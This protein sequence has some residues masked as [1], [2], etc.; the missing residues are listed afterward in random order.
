MVRAATHVCRGVRRAEVANLDNERLDSRRGAVARG[1][2]GAWVALQHRCVASSD[3]KEARVAHAEASC[4]GGLGYRRGGRTILEPAT[5]ERERGCFIAVAVI[6]AVA[7]RGTRW[8]RRREQRARRSRRR[9]WHMGRQGR[10]I[11]RWRDPR[12]HRRR[13]GRSRWR[14]RWRRPVHTAANAVTTPQ[15]ELVTS[16]AGV[17]GC[18]CGLGA[19]IAAAGR[20]RWRRR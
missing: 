9:G 11:R 18:T 7:A 4:E 5:K 16:E 6:A 14:R 3:R 15:R 12:W 13:R 10:R 17:E 2:A 19:W 1:A 8:K 20:G